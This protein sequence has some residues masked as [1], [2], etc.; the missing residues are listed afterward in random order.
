MGKRVAYIGWGS[1][2]GDQAATLMRAVLL[3][4]QAEEVR[5]RRISQWIRTE[6]VGGPAGQPPYFNGAAEIETSLSPEGLLAVLHAVEAALGRDRSREPR[7]GPRTCDLDLLLMG[8]LIVQTPSLTVPHPRMH[9]R[10]F[11]LEPLASIAPGA[12]HPALGRTVGQLLAEA[13]V[14][15]LPAPAPAAATT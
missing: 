11:V 13:P 14:S 1:N 10:R 7:W 12:I 6:A 5:V 4:D 15:P 9:Q 3:L 2:L 8:D